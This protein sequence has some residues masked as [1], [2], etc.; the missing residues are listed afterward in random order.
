MA[1]EF[2][3]ALPDA[4]GAEG[5]KRPLF[6]KRGSKLPRLVLM[7][8]R[9]LENWRPVFPERLKELFWGVLM[10]EEG[11]PSGALLVCG[12]LFWGL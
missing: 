4:V 8:W 6:W 9:L 10:E 11:L 12:A 2:S 1:G 3:P 5:W 7:G